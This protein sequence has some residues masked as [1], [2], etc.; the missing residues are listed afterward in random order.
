MP[1]WERTAQDAAE[2][3]HPPPQKP[4]NDPAFRPAWGPAIV[5]LLVALALIVYLYATGW[6]FFN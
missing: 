2:T 5:V 1:K 6:S 3:E 4:Q